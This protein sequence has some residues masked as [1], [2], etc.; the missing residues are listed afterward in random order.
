MA[1]RHIIIGASAA[2]IGA[3]NGIARAN[4][5]DHIIC[6]A[7]ESH[8][9]YNTCFLAD[10]LATEK[11]SED[12]LLPIEHIF[13][14]PHR[15][16]IT[17]AT[18]D[19]IIPHE[20]KVYCSDGTVYA[21][22]TLF[23]GTGYK[24]RTLKV[25]GADTLS[26]YFSFYYADDAVAIDRYIRTKNVRSAVIV[27]GGI[28]GLECADALRKRGLSVTVVARSGQVLTGVVDSACATCIETK[29]RAA[30][31]TVR[32][33]ATVHT[34]AS[35][36][37][38]VTGVYLS[39]G[40]CIQT[41]MVIISIGARPHGDLANQ[42]GLEIIDGA[43]RVNEYMQTSD[44][45]IWAGGD[46]AHIYDIFTGRWQPNVMWQEAM[47]QGMIAGRAMAGV[48]QKYE[49]AYSML[50]SQICGL[51]LAVAGVC[52]AYSS[53]YMVHE[54]I[55]EES[56]TLLVSK[57][58]ILVGFTVLGQTVNALKLKRALAAK[59]LINQII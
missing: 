9:P 2:G 10:M 5:D 57:A 40:S 16:I 53:E 44:A 36:N 32:H 43:I 4:T 46:C 41:D 58:G 39:D 1:K 18:V 14:A 21:Y 34:I 49:G 23:I 7:R 3:A 25:D 6:I 37:G 42:A 38:R 22:D 51:Q 13:N 31:I 28:N 59:N 26:G 54:A 8:M 29:M 45:S 52:H 15:R 24:A 19:A 11:K 30:G 20:K 33:N 27:G 35:E 47:R 17:G 56:Y 48:P 12:L 55:T 50:E